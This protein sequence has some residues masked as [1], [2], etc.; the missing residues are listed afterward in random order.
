LLDLGVSPNRIVVTG[1]DAIELAMPARRQRLGDA[2]GINLRIAQ[3]ADMSD[4]AGAAFGSAIRATGH[5]MMPLPIS[6]KEDDLGKACEA[7]G[8]SIPP[9]DIYSTPEDVIKRVRECRV[10][11]TA[12]YHAAVFALANG[13]P[14]VCIAL[15]EYY[16]Q[17]FGGLADQFGVGCR[18]VSKPA[19]LPAAIESAWEM[20]PGIQDSLLYAAQRQ[21][22]LSRQAF[23]FMKTELAMIKH[24]PHGAITSASEGR[25][26]SYSS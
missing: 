20:A 1:D 4:E 17:K 10:V 25:G 14:A 19:E 3:Y 16:H 6:M 11:V 13:I 15:S 12:S 18:L 23:E 5:R 21:V 2:L 26:F 7:V 24:Q 22:Q 9:V 8:M